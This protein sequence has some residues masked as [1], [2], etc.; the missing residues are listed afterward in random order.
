MVDPS[1]NVA[2]TVYA[3]IQEERG[4]QGTNVQQYCLCLRTHQF[5]F[6]LQDTTFIT[7]NASCHICRALFTSTNMGNCGFPS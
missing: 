5:V 4:S 7:F 1:H 6:S 3:G 2:A